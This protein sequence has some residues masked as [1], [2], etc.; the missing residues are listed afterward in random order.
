M[1]L[2][3]TAFVTTL[4]L[5]SALP[6]AADVR[7]P[8]LLSDNMVLQR[9]K[10]VRLWG[11][12]DPGERV[13]VTLGDETKAATA[14]D[15]G[16]WI[17]VLA[18]HPAGGPHD[19]TIAGKNTLKL[20]NVLFGEVW[21]CSGQSN[22]AMDLRSA[23]NGAGETD[24]AQ[25]PNIR[26]F[27]AG[28]NSLQRPAADCTGRW[29]ACTPET[30]A[31]FSAVGY[32]F[33]RGLHQD[34]NVPVG[35]VVAA[36]GGAN[37]TWWTPLAAMDKDPELADTAARGREAFAA[38]PAQP[39]DQRGW[40][41]A[42]FDDS[43]WKPM[44]LPQGWEKSGMGMDTL[45]GVV[46][47]RKAI[48]VPAEWAGQPL[49]LHLGPI[50]DGDTAYFNGQRIGSM[51]V[52]TPD[53]YKLPRT[54]PVPAAM[55]KAGKTV[56]ALRITDRL[57][58]GGLVG[59][60][61]Q[62]YLC[63]AADESKCIPLDGPWRFQI[64]DR[65]PPVGAAAG[66]Y[67]GMIAPL[68]PMAVR[69]VLWYQGEA[70]APQARQYRNLLAAMISSW[71]AAWADDA[72]PF[73]IIQ[74]PN[75]MAP[76][77]EPVDSS[78]AELRESQQFVA[79]SLKAVSLV[80]TIDIGEAENIHP[81]NKHDVAARAVRAAKAHV[82]AQPNIIGDAPS[83]VSMAIEG[84]NIRVRLANTGAGL[85]A[86]GAAIHGFSL[87]GA[88][89]KFHWADATL[90]GQD[91]LV[92]SP[93]VPAPTIVRYGWADNP[94]CTLYGKTGLPVAPFRSDAPAPRDASH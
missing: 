17:V 84:N 44:N 63:V 27:T 22:M 24:A 90:D 36:M 31:H 52:D 89:G 65:W 81:A 8:H 41:A 72:L 20:A 45:D 67:N 66:L 51:D 55:V 73:I 28:L 56:L 91:V 86:R 61:E 69:G 47:F 30:A 2:S 80:V 38:F 21:V 79:S 49:T 15:H 26:F 53:V 76:R 92:H 50:D 37:A 34:L 78:W 77:P 3:R 13:T 60:P 87:A 9:E 57:G 7:L 14:D 62:S 39:V 32:L 5:L 25:F 12:A 58:E 1:P 71:R 54:Y 46:W 23:A 4:V 70:N 42:D 29:V 16:Q 35:I 83:Y 19:I 11:S 93:A 75:Y 40:E 94:E 6:L 88:D 85:E 64:A 10:P 18:A 33:G 48:D 43:A 82:Y 68:T 74:L 59:K